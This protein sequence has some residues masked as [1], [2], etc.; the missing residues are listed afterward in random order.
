MTELPPENLLR[1]KGAGTESGSY[2]NPT[3]Q[4][5]LYCQSILVEEVLSHRTSR[6]QNNCA[7]GSGASITIAGISETSIMIMSR[8][9][10]ILSLLAVGIATDGDDDADDGDGD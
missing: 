7:M 8:D 3:S 10:D 1:Q 2:G 4:Q 9:S 5:K 6:S